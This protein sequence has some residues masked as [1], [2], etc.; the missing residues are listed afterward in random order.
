MGL[1]NDM[2]KIKENILASY[3]ERAREYQQRLKENEDLV[4]QV[5]KTLDQFRTSHLEMAANLHANAVALR[6]NLDQGEADRL[7][8]FGNL[9]TGIRNSISSIQTEVEDIRNSTAHLL[10]TFAGSRGEMAAELKEKFMQSRSDREQQD[11]DRIKAFDNLMKNVRNDLDR[12]QK[13]VGKIMSDTDNLLRKY[14]NEHAMMASTMRSNLNT[15]LE[16]RVV[17]MRNLLRNFNDRLAEIHN[18]NRIMAETLRKE[19][20]QSRKNLSASDAKRMEEFDKAMG[21]IRQR[22]GDIQ[23]SIANLLN[24]LAT[25]RMQAAAEWE[26]LTEAIA[27]IKNSVTWPSPNPVNVSVSEESSSGIKGEE[28]GTNKNEEETDGLKGKNLE[29]KIILYVNAHPE[30]VKVSE[31]EEPL[32]EQRMRIGY[33]CKK[34]V[35][36]GK[37]IK[38]DRAYFPKIKS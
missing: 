5:Q 20:L 28:E 15:N 36:E 7:N 23:S 16:E 33:V 9:M 13:E 29:E 38:L 35:D 26:S 22:V 2:K 25:D 8:A 27:W 34:L 14:A 10:E 3:E 37:I 17:Y 19:L 12:S 18:E 21:Q 1:A 6:D 31:M 32:G 4:S 24:N 30:G 11:Q